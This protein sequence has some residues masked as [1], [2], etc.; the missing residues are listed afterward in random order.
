MLVIQFQTIQAKRLYWGKPINKLL[1]MTKT[2]P[3]FKRFESVG[4][5]KESKNLIDSAITNVA[6]TNAFFSCFSVGTQM[7]KKESMVSTISCTEVTFILNY[8][9]ILSCH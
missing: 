6:T 7:E 8:G 2:K 9:G 5:L 3:S 1:P 4:N